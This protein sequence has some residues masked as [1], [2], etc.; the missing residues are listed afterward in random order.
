MKITNRRAFYDYEILDRIEAGISLSGPEVKA[1]RGGHVDL[2]G[3]FVRIRGS[4]AYLVNAKVYPYRFA[5]GEYD[6]RRTRKLLLHKPEIIALKTRTQGA[7]LA[8]VPLSL[9]IRGG[10]IKLEI[11]L[12]KGKWQFE[13]REAKRRRDIQRELGALDFP[14]EIR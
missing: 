13:K 12:G 6:E 2:K 4:E 1:I 8:L 7:G 10:F 9:Y 5:A 11:G 14:S 3:S